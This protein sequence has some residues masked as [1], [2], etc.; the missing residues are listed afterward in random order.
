MNAELALPSPGVTSVSFRRACANCVRPCLK[1]RRN[2]SKLPSGASAE[3][4]LVSAKSVLK[5]CN[6]AVVESVE[7]TRDAASA[8]PATYRNRDNISAWS[9]PGRRV[10]LKGCGVLD[11]VLDASLVC[12]EWSMT[13]GIEVGGGRIGVGG[14]GLEGNGERCSQMERLWRGGAGRRS[15]CSYLGSMLCTNGS[16]STERGWG[17]GIIGSE[18]VSEARVGVLLIELRC[19]CRRNNDRGFEEVDRVTGD[20]ITG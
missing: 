3:S 13:A 7:P 19:G 8:A 12:V 17:R 16:G 9:S 18:D 1:A 20:C 10:M 5:S 11:K 4:S 15:S 6:C 14:R 2:P